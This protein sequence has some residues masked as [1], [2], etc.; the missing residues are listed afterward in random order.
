M[1]SRR[2][3]CRYTPQGKPYKELEYMVNSDGKYVYCKYWKPPI[4]MDL[5]AGLLFLHGIAEHCERYNVFASKLS[6]SGI[7][8]FS[9]DHVGHGQSEGKRTDIKEFN[10]YVRDA[11]QHADLTRAKFKGQNV[12][13]FIGGQALGA[14]IAMLCMNASP[15][16][17]QGAILFSPML[18]SSSLYPSK[19]QE[20]I[21]NIMTFIYP[22]YETFKIEGRFISRDETNAEEYDRDQ[23]VWHDGLKARA[24]TYILKTQKRI[25]DEIRNVTWPFI[26]FHGS[27]DVYSNV[28]GSQRLYKVSQSEDKTIR[29]LPDVY[30]SILH[31]SQYADNVAEEV[32]TWIK[33]R[34]QMFDKGKYCICKTKP[35]T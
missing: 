10:V 30:H 29:I 7:F 11:L 17:F 1:K 18:L 28:E 21:S 24:V 15:V 4:G 32:L 22:Q 9:H 6:K 19:I 12:P 23:L 35:P 2:K 26:T 5:R 27:A 14:L 33:S 31:D 3:Q 8:V 16:A 20:Y 25:E 13:I 34:T